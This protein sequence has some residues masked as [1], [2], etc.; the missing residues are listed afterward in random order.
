MVFEDIHWADEGLVAFVEYLLDWWRHHP[1]F[2]LTLARPELA[3]RHPAF[4][5]ATRSATTLPLEPLDDEAMNELLAGL[6]P[7][8]PDEVRAATRGGRG[9]PALRRRDGA[10]APGPRPARPRPTASPWSPAT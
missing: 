9:D 3:D 5:G 6:V 4:P 10:H 8:L 2:V 1:I 7:G